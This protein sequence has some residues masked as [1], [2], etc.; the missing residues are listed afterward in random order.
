MDPKPTLKLHHAASILLL[1]YHNHHH[2]HHYH[3]YY[4][5]HH[6]HYYHHYHHHYHTTSPSTP[7]LAPLCSGTVPQQLGEGKWSILGVPFSFHILK[8]SII[9]TSYLSFIISPN[10]FFFLLLAYVPFSSNFD[11]FWCFHLI[12]LHY[13]IFPAFH[14]IISFI[15]FAIS[16]SNHSS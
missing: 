4:H 16:A 7:T 2:H 13:I 10:F 11:Y 5:Y 14:F 8:S 12:C 1:S 3:H 6:Y 15:S 9:F